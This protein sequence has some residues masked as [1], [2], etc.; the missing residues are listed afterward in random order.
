LEYGE[1]RQDHYGRILAYVYVK[2]SDGSFTQ[3]NEA[4]VRSGLASFY[5]TGPVELAH[6]KTLFQAQIFA[7]KCNIGIWKTFDGSKQVHTYYCV[8]ALRLVAIAA[9]ARVWVT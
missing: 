7:K 3:V 4:V 6:G 8:G 5:A 9:R 1:E 2:A